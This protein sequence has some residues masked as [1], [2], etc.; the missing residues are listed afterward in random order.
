MATFINNATSF[1]RPFNYTR[2]LTKLFPFHFPFFTFISLY[3]IFPYI[4]SSIE[5][6]P[7]KEI[8]KILHRKLAV[9]SRQLIII[10]KMSRTME[11]DWNVSQVSS[12]QISKSFFE[13]LRHSLFSL[14]PELSV[15]K[16][17]HKRASRV[18]GIEMRYILSLKIKEKRCV[19]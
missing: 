4:S 19:T 16:V 7:K 9:Y 1:W 2:S 12:Q 3:S 11:K 18:D 17:A 8:H 13:I 5:Q 10:N 15:D 14:A 6:K